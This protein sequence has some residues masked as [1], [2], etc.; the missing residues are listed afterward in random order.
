M[1]TTDIHPD[2]VE[3]YVG[4]L[5]DKI[6]RI[7]T[8]LG[9]SSWDELRIECH[10]IKGSGASYGFPRLTELSTMAERQ[11]IEGSARRAECIEELLAAMEKILKERKTQ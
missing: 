2:L 4:K 3:K 8:L 10:R 5:S 6:G 11:I 7:R 9:S 1:M